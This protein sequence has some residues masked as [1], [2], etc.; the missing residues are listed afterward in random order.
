MSSKSICV[1]A[2]PLKYTYG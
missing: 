1:Y 2:A